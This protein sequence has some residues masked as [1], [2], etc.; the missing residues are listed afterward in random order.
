MADLNKLSPEALKAAMKGGTAEWGRRASATEHV[1][2]VQP[3]KATARRECCCGCGGR[4][5]H[6]AFANGI[7]LAGGCELSMRR[8]AKEMSGGRVT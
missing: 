4:E 1:L 8:W 2:Y 3:N 6:G 5:T 7:V